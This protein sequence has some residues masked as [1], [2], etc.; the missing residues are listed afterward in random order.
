M[1]SRALLGS[2]SALGGTN[3]LVSVDAMQEFRIQTSTYAPE[4]GR[5]PGGQIS[6]VTRSGTNQFHG[7]AFSIICEMMFW[8]PTIGLTVTTI[9]L[10]LPKA[11]ERQN[12][13]GGTFG[14]P[15]FKDRTFFFFSY[16]GL[17]LRLP[18]TTLSMVPDT[19]ARQNAVSAM[20]PFLN[21]FPISNGA[22][23]IATG[24]A[25]FNASYS[26]PATLNA[27]SLR[28][29]HKLSDKLG[30]F[31]RYAYSPSELLQRG[32]GSALSTVYS[33]KITTQTVTVGT[34]WAISSELVNDLRFNYSRTN[35]TTLSYLDNFGGAVPLASPPF[36]SPFTNQN[37]QLFLNVFTAG[38]LNSGPL[39]DNTQRQ[40]NVVEGLALQKGRHSLKFGIDFRRLNPIYGNPGYVQEALF[41]TMPSFSGGAPFLSFVTSTHSDILFHL[42][43]LGV[44][45]Q[46]TWR[47][48]TRLV[49]TYGLRWDVDFAPTSNPS[50]L[51]VTGFNLQDLSQ[52]ALAPNGTA[53]FITT[54]G[55]FAP[56]LGVA[57]E[58]H[59]NQDTQTVVRGGFGLFY[60]LATSELGN[61]IS[62]YYYPFGATSEISGA[63]YPLSSANAAPP[64]IT[65]AS[66]PA[67][68]LF[69]FDPHLNLPYTV[70]W[71][72]AVEQAL[73]RQQT[74]SA[75]YIGSVGRR[76]IQSA[77]V[78]APNQNFGGVTLVTNAATSDYNA[79]QVQFQ[80]RM[81]EGLQALASYTWSHSIDTASAGS[82]YGNEANA[83]VPSI[84]VNANR[85][86]SDFDTRNA[87]SAGVSYEVPH[88]KAGALVNAALGGW[89]TDF[90]V[91]AHSAPPVTVYDGSIYNLST[92]AVAFIRPDVVPGQPS[93]LY[94]I[95]CATAF[96][97]LGELPPG[98]S[99]PGGKGFNP[100]AFTPPPT[101]SNGYA[102]S[103]GNLPRNALRGFGATQLDFAVH[104]EFPIHESLKLQFRAEMFNILNHPNFAPPLQDIS[105]SEACCFGLSTQTLNQYL[106]GGS[107][108]SGGFSPLYQIGG[109][110]S[111]QFAL[112][113]MF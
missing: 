27:Y 23:D 68:N 31:I 5:T 60:D 95:Q 46:D 70:E 105:N 96:Q 52:I 35:N 59:Q 63:S 28:L 110:R 93:Y 64:P 75:S 67:S 100:A 65:V 9:S 43:N 66:L 41:S 56:R 15:I 86:P 81:S 2:F 6:I 11:K 78:N 14:G 108:G 33:S 17:R 76:L 106:A 92:G 16:E 47:V 101:D 38:L 22:D 74:L 111:I 34:T 1:D 94:G 71:N 91:Q 45:A 36:P 10:P 62:P 29:D 44:F 7:T 77:S 80:R 54:Y 8:T 87:F 37:G 113:M 51:A 12:D 109:P 89:S 85:G 69:A 97:A 30:A 102:L 25:A 39:G 26:D 72:V 32:N 112:K 18:Q 73:G 57:Y 88:P 58:V 99:C 84:N 103:Q 19:S 21:A 3:S 48:T 107:V 82:L 50:L 40:I 53:P 79:L 42:H 55:N 4:F 61:N 90:I 104:R 24:A 83:L 13:F 20:Q 98:V 49:L